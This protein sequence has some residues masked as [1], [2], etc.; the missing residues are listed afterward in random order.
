MGSI[1]E[2]Y[3]VTVAEI[4]EWNGLSN[5]TVHYGTSL[6]IAKNGL[7]SKKELTLNPERKDIEYVVLKGDNLGNIANITITGGSSGQVI[8]TNGSGVLS[9]S[10]PAVPTLSSAVDE[11][12]GTGTQ[13]QFV[14]SATP[15]NKN[16]TFA[17]IQGIMQPKSS[18]TLAGAILTF[19]S[20]P[21]NTAFIEVTTLGLS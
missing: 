13:T 8:T 11:F 12:T 20:P 3:E 21:P 14:L 15:T 6:Q 18:Y 19:S 5:D 10:T 4:Q 7:D 9:F 1:A 17:V 2:K 16:F